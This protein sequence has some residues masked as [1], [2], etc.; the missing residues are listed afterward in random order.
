MAPTAGCSTESPAAAVWVVAEGAVVVAEIP[1][2]NGTFEAAAAPWNITAGVV[3]VGF[4][5]A[6]VLAGLRTLLLG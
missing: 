1:D 4:A 5:V 3:A 6:V 2:V